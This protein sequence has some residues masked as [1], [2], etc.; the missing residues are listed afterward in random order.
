MLKPTDEIL[1]TLQVVKVSDTL[2]M[3]MSPELPG[4]MV[5]G[6]SFEEAVGRVPGVFRDLITA[7]NASKHHTDQKAAFAKVAMEPK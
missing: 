2:L 4:M 1:C 5:H 7:L 6:R 3:V